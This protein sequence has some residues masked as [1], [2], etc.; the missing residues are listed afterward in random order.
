[1]VNTVWCGDLANE[2]IHITLD[3]AVCFDLVLR[4]V[5]VAGA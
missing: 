1:M 3:E 4:A 5:F 2:Y